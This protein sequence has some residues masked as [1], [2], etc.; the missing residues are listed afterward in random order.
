MLLDLVTRSITSEIKFFK[1]FQGSASIMWH[2]LIKS[3]SLVAVIGLTGFQTRATAQSVDHPHII[4]V[5][6]DDM[7]WGQTGYRG[8]PVLKTPNLDAM[9]AKGL[10][11]DRFYA[12][13][14]T[15]SPTRATVL[16]GRSNDRAN[17]RDHGYA[18]RLQEKTLATALQSAGYMT[19]HFGK[20]HLNGYRGPGVPILDTDTHHPGHF[21]FTHWLSVTNFFDRDP[22]LSRMGRWESFRGDSSEIIVD[23]AIEFI[24]QQPTGGQPLFVVIWYGSP[25]SPFDAT[26]DDIADFA[27]LKPTDRDHH[28]ELVAMDRS[29]GTLRKGLDDLQLAD[30]T[31]LWFCSDNGGLPKIMPSTTGGLRGNKGTIYEGGLRVPAIV[32]WPGGIKAP[33]VSNYPS[34]TMDIFPT[35]AEIVGLPDAVMQQPQDGRSLLP[36]FSE[37]LA[38][39][40]KPIP[41]RQQGRGA[42]TDN[43]YKLLTTDYT[44]GQFEL[45]DLLS[46]PAETK[47][48]AASHPDIAKQ[49]RGRWTA[50]NETVEQSIAGED[51]PEGKVNDGE[52]QPRQWADDAAYAPYLKRLESQVAPE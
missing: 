10:R 35:I 49:M 3:V 21:G 16:T 19:A 31:L 29:I 22:W 34:C 12:G 6:A 2:V 50:W 41:F 36:L 15:C 18:L 27:S 42:W 30:N 23:Q 43:Q 11:L 32:Q 48:L 17:V 13:A 45:Y 52:P 47:N 4:L 44:K 33:R 8:H 39:R 37:E 40:D 20:W 28:G 7:G 26:A 1:R 14:A 46:D 9:A 38:A 51:Y 24:K 25:H 5:M